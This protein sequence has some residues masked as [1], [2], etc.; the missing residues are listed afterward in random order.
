MEQGYAIGPLAK[1]R[2]GNNKQL[3]R[4]NAMQILIWYIAQVT[5]YVIDDWF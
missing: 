5:F 2:V 1:Q 4:A 3:C